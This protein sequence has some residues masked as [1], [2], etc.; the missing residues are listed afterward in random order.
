MK[1]VKVLLV[2]DE[3]LALQ[4]LENFVKEIPDLEIIGKV[5]SPIAAIDILN[6]EPIDI[7]FLDIQMPTLNGVNLLKT[8]IH[9]PVTIFTT[10]YAEYALDAF[11]LDAVDYLLKPFS[12]ERFLQA[13]NKAKQLLDTKSNDDTI[14]NPILKSKTIESITIKSDAKIIKIMVDEIVFIEGLKE[15]VKIVCKNEKYITLMSLKQLILDLPYDQFI[16]VHKSYIVNS[17]M[18]DAIEGNMLHVG[19][20]KIPVSRDR[21]SDIVKRIFGEIK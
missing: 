2:D 5:K 13:V 18:V 17:V 1:T 16:R 20:E 6:K 7:L 12:F 9:K 3:Y 15:Y 8:L 19:D 11:G 21:K 14:V 4:L 10:A